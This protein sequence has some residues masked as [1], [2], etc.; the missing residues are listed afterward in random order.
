MILKNERNLLRPAKSIAE[1]MIKVDHTGENGAV[2]IYRAQRL[3]SHIRARHLIPQLTEFQSHEEE[4]RDIFKTRLNEMGIRQCVSYHLSGIGG[5][6]LGLITGLIGPSAIAA[7]TYAVEDVVL[8][9]LEHQMPILQETDPES[10][11]AVRR[12]Y[13]D[14]MEHH[15]TAEV[16]MQQNKVLTKLL[17]WVV[18]LCTEGVILFGMR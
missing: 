13:D 5:F 15:Q 16:Q 9:H 3:I 8:S 18:K 6:V 4:H 17:V 7:T 2:N 1:K 14:E 10:Y 12:I 11:K